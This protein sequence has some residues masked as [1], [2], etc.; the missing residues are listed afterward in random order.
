M[1]CAA[2]TDCPFE[3]VG[4]EMIGGTTGHFEIHV[5]VTTADIEGFREACA[6]LGV[7]P[8]VIEFQKWLDGPTD[9]QVMTTHRIVG[10]YHDAYFS[11]MAVGHT[12]NLQDF[13][14]TRTKIECGPADA[15]SLPIL[16]MESHLA[17]NLFE[18]DVDQL[19]QHASDIGV[20]M[21]RNAFKK[22]KGLLK[23]TYMVTIREYDID[24]GPFVGHTKYI[25]DSFARQGFGRARLIIEGC[26]YDSNQDMDKE[27][28]EP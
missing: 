15:G 5:T 25:R 26:V 6:E 10:T 28:I 13:E 11:A 23:S 14:V 22:D 1:I 24:P 9:T 8:I 7:K 27:W 4:L 20:H 3:L 12:L 16:Y 21:S 17:F 19:R 18:H 2:C